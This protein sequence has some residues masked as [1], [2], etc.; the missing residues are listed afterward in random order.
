MFTGPAAAKT[1]AR[2][3]HNNNFTIKTVFFITTSALQT[4]N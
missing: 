1:A 4:I 3:L 2:A